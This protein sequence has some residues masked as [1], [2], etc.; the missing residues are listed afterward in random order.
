MFYKSLKN[1]YIILE[2]KIELKKTD[3]TI[4]IKVPDTK[5]KYKRHIFKSQYRNFFKCTK[6]HIFP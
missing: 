5:Q 3:T 2:I 6:N 4:F 1:I